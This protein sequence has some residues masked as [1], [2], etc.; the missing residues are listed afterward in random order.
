MKTIKV[1]SASPP[2]ELIFTPEV[3]SAIVD[4]I[5]AEARKRV[6]ANVPK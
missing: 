2:G 4:W 3:I 5:E 1:E 6:E